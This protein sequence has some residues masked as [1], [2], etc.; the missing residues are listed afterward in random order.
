M[1]S[2]VPLMV[3]T[4]GRTGSTLL[5]QI[6]GTNE[7]ICFERLYPFEHRYLTYAYN[8]ARMP[9]L[10]PQMD[11]QWNNDSM[12]RC[13]ATAVGCLPYGKLNTIDKESLAKNLF[14]SI[15]KELSHNIKT[16]Q[17]LPHS[18]PCF[19]A[20]KVPH[21]VADRSNE[22]LNARSIF[23]LRDPR[24]EMVSIKQF[25]IKRGFHS[26]GWTEDD[27]DVSYAQKMCRNRIKFLHHMMSFTTEQHRI[28]FRYEDLVLKG[29]EE[30]SRLSEWLGLDL[31][32]QSA[33]SDKSVKSRHM[34][35]KSPAASVE[36]WRAELSEEVKAIFA[37]ELGDELIQLGYSI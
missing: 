4:F 6:L 37:K 22:L 21:Q 18:E 23:L 9:S 33:I 14:V 20:E 35:S 28:R 12:F 32:Y 30:V 19:Y 13:N 24:D 26:F 16:T 29:P 15:W 11:E 10:P 5:M 25:N 31:D 36:R 3:R 17:G 8:L 2:L 27:T 7:R 34:T 1:T